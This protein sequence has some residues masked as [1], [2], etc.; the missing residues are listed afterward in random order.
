[1]HDKMRRP[2][3]SSGRS[4]R[5]AQQG[6]PVPKSLRIIELGHWDHGAETIVK[7]DHGNAFNAGCAAVGYRFLIDRLQLRGKL[8]HLARANS[9]AK[10]NCPREARHRPPL[11]IDGSPSGPR[12][13]LA[14][15]LHH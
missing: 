4:P 7:P 5:A 12:P 10:V 13:T 9:F 15:R 14:H 1:M 3:K 8:E 11:K 2:A 6:I